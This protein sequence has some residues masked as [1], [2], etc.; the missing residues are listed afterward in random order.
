MLGD[1]VYGIDPSNA[2]SE[3]GTVRKTAIYNCGARLVL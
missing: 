2:L 1:A 3:F